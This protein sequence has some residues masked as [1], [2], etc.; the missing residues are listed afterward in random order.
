MHKQGGYELMVPRNSAESGNDQQIKT[1]FA[2]TFKLSST[3][4][5]LGSSPTTRQ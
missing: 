3:T 1:G 4:Y 5:D 2:K